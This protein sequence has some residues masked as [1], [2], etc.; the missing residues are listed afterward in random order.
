MDD[1]VG[2]AV[3]FPLAT[4]HRWLMGVF[5]RSLASTYVLERTETS[6]RAWKRQRHRYIMWQ[7]VNGVVG[8]IGFNM[9]SGD[10]INAGWGKVLSS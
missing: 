1:R 2:K 4:P 10:E 5:C 9:Q 8:C 6:P 3:S 7:F